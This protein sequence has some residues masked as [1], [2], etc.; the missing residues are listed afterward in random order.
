MIIYR[1][2]PPPCRTVA[3]STREFCIQAMSSRFD[4]RDNSEN[5]KQDSNDMS[6]GEIL[7]TVI[8]SLTLLVGIISLFRCS[9][10]RHWVSSSI[11]PAVK[12]YLPFPALPKPI[13]LHILNLIILHRK[14]PALSFQTLSRLPQRTQVSTQS[15]CL[16]LSTFT[17]NIP[18]PS[19]LARVL[20]LF[21]AVEMAPREGIIEH[22]T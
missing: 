1:F 5:Q 7:A 15:L 8:A 18:M 16:T 22:C 20:T 12:V 14:P 21:C 3:Y 9:R 17:I 2:Q 4:K 10:F 11:S 6:L 19:L 13:S